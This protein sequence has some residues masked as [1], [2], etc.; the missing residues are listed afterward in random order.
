MIWNFVRFK[1]FFLG[2]MGI[3]IVYTAGVDML[4]IISVFT[5]FEKIV[6]CFLLLQ[7][8]FTSLYLL[9]W[10]LEPISPELKWGADK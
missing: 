2:L 7:L 3:I 1:V 8:I 5:S 10:G 6:L 9:A 4:S